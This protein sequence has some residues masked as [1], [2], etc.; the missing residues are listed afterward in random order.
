M[1]CVKGLNSDCLSPALMIDPL[2]SCHFLI[3][4]MSNEKIHTQQLLLSFTQWG[5]G[6]GGV[7][8]PWCVVAAW[9]SNEL[10]SSQENTL[11]FHFS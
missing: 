9:V 1:D 2:I 5:S 7:T 10:V 8:G 3:V 11:L 6:L 4:I